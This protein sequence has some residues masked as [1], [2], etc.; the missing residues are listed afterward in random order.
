MLATDPS[1]QHD[2]SCDKS[3]YIFFQCVNW[4]VKKA[5]CRLPLGSLAPRPSATLCII[6][7][8]VITYSSVFN[9]AV[10]CWI[11]SPHPNSPCH[12][13]TNF[14][15]RDSTS[16]T[17]HMLLTFPP[18]SITLYV[19]LMFPSLNSTLSAS[20]ILCLVL[21]FPSASFS[22]I[23]YIMFSADIPISQL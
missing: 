7:A 3:D 14:V 8:L 4:C 22:S 9:N 11:P 2:C 21:T 19:Q 18:F 15:S 16:I 17:L 10:V 23:I 20:F 13:H 12:V 6:N 5:A 1:K